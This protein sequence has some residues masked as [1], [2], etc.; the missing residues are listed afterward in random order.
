MKKLTL[1]IDA[2]R[3]ESFQVDPAVADVRGTV[4]GAAVTT[5]ANTFPGSQY[6]SNCMPQ[7]D[8]GQGWAI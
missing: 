4:H 8:W 2:L 5:D 1:E 3:V 7:Q 6:V